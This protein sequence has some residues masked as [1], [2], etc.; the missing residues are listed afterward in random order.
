MRLEVLPEVL[1]GVDP[2]VL[3]ECS[4]A[5]QGL[6]FTHLAAKAVKGGRRLDMQLPFL[7]GWGCCT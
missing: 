7:R 4:S 3:C 2:D 1:V 6:L 5:L